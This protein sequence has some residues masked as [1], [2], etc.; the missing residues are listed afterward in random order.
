M[1]GNRPPRPPPIATYLASKLVGYHEIL[2]FSNAPKETDF[3][4]KN[5]TSFI[6]PFGKTY[7]AKEM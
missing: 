7:S 3:R 6:G 2:P 5:A 4:S 1:L